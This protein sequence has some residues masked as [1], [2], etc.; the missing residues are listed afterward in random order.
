MTR[1]KLALA[2]LSYWWRTNAG[3]AAGT[4]VA[5]TVLAGA[6][7]VG[8][9]VRFSLRRSAT[10]RLGRVSLAMDAR[11]R[12]FRAALADEVGRALDAPAA[13]VIAL[14]GTAADPDSGPR[15]N[16][17]HVLG[18]DGR[19]W[20][21]ARNQTPLDLADD[22]AALGARLAARLGLREGGWVVV[23]VRRGGALPG[24]APL[25]GEG[26]WSAARLRV[27]AVVD[28]EHMGA[29]ALTEGQAPALD[30]FV[31]P[32]T[33]CKLA[34]RADVRNMLLVG[35][36]SGAAGPGGSEASVALNADCALA[37]LGLELRRLPAGGAELRGSRVFLEAPAVRAATEVDPGAIGVL[38]YFVYE[39]RKGEAASPY[40]FV[41]AIGPLDGQSGAAALPAP[42][43]GKLAPGTIVINRWLAD[44]I[45]AGVGDRLTLSY[46]VLS[47]GGGLSSGRASFEVAGVVSMTGLAADA[48]L[49]PDFPGLADVTDCTDWRPGVPID[50]A[51]IRPKDEDYWRERRGTPKAFISL[52]DGRRLWENRFGDLT[53][54]RFAAAD[55]D[56]AALARRIRERIDPAAMGLT[57]TPV[58]AMAAAS[59]D[60]ALDFGQLFL[61]LSI[62]LVVAAV[63]LTALLLALAADQRASEA[64]TL[65][66]IGWTRRAV[67]LSLLGELLVPAAA[68]CAAGCLCGVAYTR[69]VI[70]A[71][72]TIWSG[73]VA[74]ATLHF[75]VQAGSIAVGAAAAMACAAGA[76]WAVLRFH[77]RRP[78]TALL[79]GQPASPALGRASRLRS[80]AMLVAGVAFCAAAVATALLAHHGRDRQAAGAFFGAGSQ[81][82]A[83]MLLLA[84][85][86]L[87]SMG[88]TR[89]AARLGEAELAMRNAARRPGRSLAVVAMFACGVFLVTA[90]AA[91]RRDLA[92]ASADRASG[93]GGFALFAGTSTPI[94]ADVD[95]PAGLNK[96]G[97]DEATMNGVKVVPLRLQGGDD[98]SCLNLG[99]AQRPRLLGVDPRLLVE[100]RAFTFVD[101]A[102][103]EDMAA[104]WDLLNADLGAGVVPAVGDDATVVWGLGLKPG[105][106]LAYTDG[107]GRQF[108][109]RIVGVIAGSIFQG[110]LLISRD[111]FEARFPDASGFGRFL[112]DAPPAE[113]A[114]IARAMEQ[115]GGD[116]GMVV[117][118][119]GE[120][121][122][123]FR[124]VENTYL[125]IFQAL[126]GLGLILGAAAV[127]VVAGRNVMERRGE[128]AAMRAV[129]FTRKKLRGLTVA[130]HAAM[131]LAGLA[132]GAVA[133]VVASL[134]AIVSPDADVAWEWLGIMLATVAACA[135]AF[136]GAACREAM[137]GPLLDALRRE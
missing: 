39:V 119:A 98:A 106:E 82:L 69:G 89:S 93:T 63:A 80:R 87:R 107:R 21:L 62:F 5:A 54:V 8:D 131:V 22:E 6:L 10:E 73:A 37:D 42:L 121:L 19:F 85:W 29:F 26:Q 127:A 24:E 72:G 74:G 49:M 17:V 47:A 109:L 114:A 95:S 7:A 48:G 71:L 135:V 137:R 123:G 79:G 111:S 15:A 125:S 97:L 52:A 30:A 64:G 46:P 110:S 83:G 27:A 40:A 132:A 81:L 12:F 96:L 116:Y 104:G 13:G 78:V 115:S 33:A 61:G 9:S 68:G 3:I 130:E 36:R 126:G 133:A 44:D 129:G 35:R 28:D 60:Q 88:R 16:D 70:W 50:L 105:D 124:R 76:G 134:P 99:R 51:G 103:G 59:A 1:L 75:H 108:R 128:L 122:A 118:P 67:R 34:G 20:N 65:L 45:D 66:A 94:V 90:V 41:S 18:V 91:N 86:V 92:R 117:R 2:G 32:T 23:R 100:R 84:W 11:G 56:E 53:A 113:S 38:T 25:S 55:A 31:T 77:M 4:A 57:F 43:D 136:V 58:A 101:A 112:I 14:R 120:V 102:P